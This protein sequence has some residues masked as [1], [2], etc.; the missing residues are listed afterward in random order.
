MQPR[1]CGLGEREGASSKGRSSSGPTLAS[2]RPWLESVILGSEQPRALPA[3]EAGRL[4][5][6]FLGRG[7][8]PGTLGPC[9]QMSPEVVGAPCQSPK[10]LGRWK[11]PWIRSLEAQAPG[12]FAL[13]LLDYSG[14]SL[15][16]PGNR[17]PPGDT[18]VWSLV[19]S[20]IPSCSELLISLVCLRGSD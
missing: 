16:L 17:F 1:L 13:N 5:R 18:R 7:G 9:A 3:L 11:E 8:Q 20:K 4:Q 12:P 14:R 6:A 19:N 2:A 10:G 15:S